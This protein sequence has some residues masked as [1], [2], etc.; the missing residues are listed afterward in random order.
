MVKIS[1]LLFLFSCFGSSL[2]AQDATTID[3]PDTTHTQGL[4]TAPVTH[5][6]L[7]QI[8]IQYGH[9]S[10]T[11]GYAPIREV[12]MT[13]QNLAFVDDVFYPTPSITGVITNPIIRIKGVVLTANSTPED[14]LKQARFD[15]LMALPTFRQMV[16]LQ[17]Y[18]MR[19]NGLISPSHF[20]F[21][22]PS[23]FADSTDIPFLGGQ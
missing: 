22:L 10:Y 8:K 20:F 16:E 21:S 1:L 6:A 12:V 15:S 7:D 2:Y 23:A 19:D 17:L 9:E 13:I 3:V 5:L 14:S 11:G 18:A 4:Q